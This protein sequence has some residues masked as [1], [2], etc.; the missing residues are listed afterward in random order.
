MQLH[1]LLKNLQEQS[2]SLVSILSIK[3]L[4]WCVFCCFGLVFLSKEIADPIKSVI[5]SIPIIHLFRAYIKHQ[6]NYKILLGFF[7]PYQLNTDFTL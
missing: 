4:V 5:G 7:Q 3:S 1:L 2:C 6:I